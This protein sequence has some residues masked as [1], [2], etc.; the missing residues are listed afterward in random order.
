[1]DVLRRKIRSM[2][3]RFL[4]I[5]LANEIKLY[6]QVKQSN[7]TTSGTRIMVIIAKITFDFLFVIRL[8]DLDNQSIQHLVTIKS[9]DLGI[10]DLDTRLRSHVIDMK[11][12]LSQCSLSF[13]GYHLHLR[14]FSSP[15]FYQCFE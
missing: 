15:A 7:R 14:H 4:A 5:L 2:I 3:F 11:L 6:R 12:S 1:M 9:D 13:A 10:L 8:N